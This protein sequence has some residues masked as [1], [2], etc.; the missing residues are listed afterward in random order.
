MDFITDFPLSKQGPAVY[1]AI[2]VIV[3][4]YTKM[5]RYILTTKTVTA[6]ELAE[7]YINEVLWF[8]GLLLGIVL[9]RGSLFTSQFWADFC[10]AANIKR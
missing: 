1:D 3:D 7:I 6:T 2:L 10:F 9:D 4:R 5:A 8:F